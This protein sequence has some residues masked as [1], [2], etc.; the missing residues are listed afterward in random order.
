MGAS[1]GSPVVEP[2][3]PAGGVCIA[4]IDLSRP[5]S[6][7]LVGTIRA[8]ILAHHVVVLA[9]QS[10]NREQQARLAA[11]FGRVEAHGSDRGERKRE[12]VAHVLSNVDADGAPTI[13]FS[14]A[15]NYHWHTD[16][17][18]RAAPPS[19][20]LL[21]AV[22]VP[23]AGSGGGGDTEFANTAL[24]YDVLPEA[25]RRRIAGLRVAFRPAFDPRLPE[26]DH[27]LVRTH[28]ETGR[29]ALYLGN[30]ATHI[31]G[32]PQAE[33]C[34]LLA[35]LLAHATRPEFVYAHRW[36]PGDLVIWDNRVLLHRLVLGD[37]LRRHRRVMHR[38]TVAGTVPF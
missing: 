9:G 21:Y 33:G 2:L 15:A 29:K 5:L 6:P 4:R 30:H 20:T 14:P 12:D 34:A 31:A 22:E 28:P 35:A 13:R 37:G 18:Y 24:A 38:S 36:R 26:V 7:E 11:D 32:M 1:N 27:P 23:P 3:S 8:A 19:L 10:L 25:T 16:K 17:P